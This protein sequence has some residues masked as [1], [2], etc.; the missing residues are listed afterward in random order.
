MPYPGYYPNNQE[1]RRLFGFSTKSILAAMEERL[2]AY[3]RNCEARMQ[4]HEQHC[5]EE[6][7]RFERL[8][9]KLDNEQ[10]TRHRENLKKFDKINYI[11]ATAIGGGIVLASIGTFI[12]HTLVSKL[13]LG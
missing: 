11:I 2:Q 12:A 3:E 8:I 9:E 4:A 1:R 7:E 10:D 6:R 5:R 13:G